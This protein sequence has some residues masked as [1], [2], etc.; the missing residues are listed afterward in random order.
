MVRYELQLFA[1]YFQIYLEDESRDRSDLGWLAP[2]H[3]EQGVADLFLV[4]SGKIVIMTVR[5]M[6][7]PLTIEVTDTLNEAHHEKLFKAADHVLVVMGCT[8]Y[9]PAAKRIPLEPDIYQC[10]IYY[11]GLD[12]LSQNG[13]E[14]DDKYRILL[15]RGIRV[16]PNILKRRKQS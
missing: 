3:F 6:T 1:D 14:G 9:Y 11:T 16:E 15:Y 12:T 8:D 7:V 10:R 13:L 5:N 2:Q 4:D